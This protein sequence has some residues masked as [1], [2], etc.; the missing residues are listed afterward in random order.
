MQFRIPTRRSLIQKF[1]HLLIYPWIRFYIKRT[2]TYR[3]KGFNLLVFNGVFHP[4]FFFSTKFLYRF[5]D[6][7]PLHGRACL[8]LGCGAGLLTLLMA[9]KGGQ[10]TAVDIDLKAVENTRVNIS[11]NEQQL[12]TKPLILQSDLFDAVGETL[13]DVIVINPPYF[14]EDVKNDTQLAWFCGKNGEYFHK[15]FSQLGRHIHDK[16]QLFMILADN[17][18]IERIRAIAATHNYRFELANKK[19]IWWEDNFIFAISLI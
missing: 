8:E 12:I 19:R 6:K 4:G 11:K 3:Y 10:V 14:F 17:C 13:F 9:R 18:D 16:S 2:R 15:L 7:L 1:Y 5:I